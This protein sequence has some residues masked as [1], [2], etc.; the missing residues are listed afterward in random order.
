MLVGGGIAAAVV[1]ATAQGSGSGTIT[2]GTSP[3]RGQ[4]TLSVDLK[5]QASDGNFIPGD[6]GVNG[7]LV[8]F[9][10]TNPNDNP[11]LVKTVTFTSVTSTNVACQAV[12]SA[13][14]SQFDQSPAVVTQNTAVPA[15]AVDFLLPASAVLEWQLE[16][17]L[18]QT[19]CLGAPLTV[20]ESTP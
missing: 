6:V 18:D 16:T 15:N 13:E 7:A 1:L 5:T 2:A 9:D 3:G 12:I 14:P 20:T 11:V 17:N 19:P 8:H 10:V 4:V